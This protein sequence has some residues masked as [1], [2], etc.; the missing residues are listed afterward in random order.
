MSYQD[1][2]NKLTAGNGKPHDGG[3][4]SK[5]TPYTLKYTVMSGG[6]YL[7]Q[8]YDFLSRIM[9]THIQSSGPAV[10]VVPFA[11]LDPEVLAAMRQ[12]LVDLGGTPP[13]LPAERGLG[14]LNL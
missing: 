13:A 8:H 11:Q 2:F 14:K 6:T 7:Y 12:K 4:W 9:T 3:E 1:E 5:L 10:A